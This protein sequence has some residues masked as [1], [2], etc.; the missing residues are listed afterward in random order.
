[1][2]RN[3]DQEVVFQTS[4]RRYQRRAIFRPFKHVPDRHPVAK[5]SAG[6]IHEQPETVFHRPRWYPEATLPAI[7]SA[8]PPCATHLNRRRRLERPQDLA[9]R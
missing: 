1:M 4:T 2:L 8:P 7:A 5:D 9:K 3:D 6:G